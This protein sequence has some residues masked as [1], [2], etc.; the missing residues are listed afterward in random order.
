[1]NKTLLEQFAQ[2]A[3]QKAKSRL[4]LKMFPVGGIDTPFKQLKHDEK[5]EYFEMMVEAG[6]NFARNNNICKQ[7]IYDCCPVLQ[8]EELMKALD[9]VDPYDV[10]AK[11]MDIAEIDEL[12]L[13][14]FKWQGIIKD[15]TSI[16]TDELEKN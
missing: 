7:M 2:K 13:K 9:V 11:L 3:E 10:V 6:T 15:D 1:M 5:L 14:L 16:D 4:E 12:G 8:D